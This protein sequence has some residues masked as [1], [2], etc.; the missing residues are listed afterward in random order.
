MELLEAL[1]LYEPEELSNGQI[2]MHCAFTE[3]HSKDSQSRKQCYISL[4]KGW[5]HCFS[6]NSSGTLKRLLIEKIGLPH[7]AALEI[8]AKSVSDKPRFKKE[9]VFEINEPWEIKPSPVFSTRGITDKIQ[10]RFKVGIT[11][12]GLTAIPYYFE[13]KLIAVQYRRGV[14]KEDR[15]LK[16]VTGFKK[17]EHIYN[18]NSGIKECVLVEGYTDVFRIEQFGFHAEGLWGTSFSEKQAEL[19]SRHKR[20]Y[21]ATDNDKAGRVALEQINFMLSR[22]DVEI[23]IVPYSEKDP[24]E[25]TRRLKWKNAMDNATS[26][27][28]YAYSM[29]L[30]NKEYLE[31]KNK[32]LNKY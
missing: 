29:M 27:P 21:I 11:K 7:F 10:K 12:T 16:N 4:E 24:G 17:S 8:V 18:Y 15:F 26:Y 14:K 2:K 23:K 9:F 19:L 30:Y 13:N 3:L 22:Y 32:A 5:F 1:S 6:C 31:I 28:E 20:I 25:C